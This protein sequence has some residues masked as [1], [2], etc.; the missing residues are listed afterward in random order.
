MIKY[1]IEKHLGNYVCVH[2]YSGEIY[3]GILEKYVPDPDGYCHAR[4]Y[5]V[6]SKNGVECRFRASDVRKLSEGRTYGQKRED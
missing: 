3:F 1:T 2:L 6:R 4:E 5:I